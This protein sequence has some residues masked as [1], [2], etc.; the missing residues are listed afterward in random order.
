MD[1]LERNALIDYFVEVWGISEDYI[2]AAI[3]ILEEQVRGRNLKDMVKA[4]TD[5]Q[6]DNPDCNPQAMKRDILEFLSEIAMADGGIDE[7]EEMALEVVERE[8]NTNLSLSSSTLRT[9]TQSVSLASKSTSNLVNTVSDKALSI[10][11][12]K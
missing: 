8:L 11:R 1:E 10:F 3:P 5:F 6:A 7:R 9:V 2:K 4:L 12:R